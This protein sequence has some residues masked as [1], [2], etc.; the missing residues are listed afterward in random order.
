MSLHD[1]K[2]TIRLWTDDDLKN[3]RLS[4]GEPTIY[5]HLAEV[6]KLCSDLGVERIAVSTNGSAPLK[7][8]QEL[9]DNGAN[10]FSVSLDACCSEDGDF[11]AGGVKGAFAKVARG[12]EFLSAR[13]YV[14]V[15]VVLTN[16]NVDKVPDV[17]AFADSLGVSDIRIIPAA[18]HDDRLHELTLS[19][20]ILSKYPI[21]RYRAKN[22]T[23]KIPVRGLNKSDTHKCGL[24]LDD[25]AVNHNL[26]YPCIIYMREGGEPIGTV[27]EDMRLERLRWYHETDTHKDNICKKNC[28]DVC[29]SFNN[30]KEVHK[31]AN[32][33]PSNRR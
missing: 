27:S 10:D 16:E 19:E 24:V 11:M 5:P 18:Q 26:H 13:T 31:A 8:Y 29:V 15:G 7:L 20:D 23:E 2:R 6:V 25:M 17:V 22:V 12:I 1:V 32:T 14:T 30:K 3:I 33:L 28:L 21:L 4:G 9:L